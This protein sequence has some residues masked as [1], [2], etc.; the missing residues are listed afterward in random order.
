M[1]LNGYSPQCSARKT[2]DVNV[3]VLIAICATAVCGS[4]F[5]SLVME[6]DLT[7]MCGVMLLCGVIAFVFGLPSNVNYGKR[8]ITSIGYVLRYCAMKLY[9]RVLQYV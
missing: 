4:A 5:M 7:T 2:T 1:D 6:S 3:F 9:E 8:Y